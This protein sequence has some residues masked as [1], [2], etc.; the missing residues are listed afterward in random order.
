MTYFNF[1][2]CRV[3]KSGAAFAAATSE[4]QDSWFDFLSMVE[5]TGWTVFSRE[6]KKH[7]QS[8]CEFYE[9]SV[10]LG[11]LDLPSPREDRVLELTSCIFADNDGDDFTAS[12]TRVKIKTCVFSNPDSRYTQQQNENSQFATHATRLSLEVWAP[13]YCN[14]PT[15][16]RPTKLVLATPTASSAFAETQGLSASVMT[17]SKIVGDSLLPDSVEYKPT[18]IFVPTDEVS[19]SGACSASS[20]LAI[21]SEVDATIAIP[22]SDDLDDSVANL[23]S[24]GFVDSTVLV[25]TQNLPA[26]SPLTNSVPILESERLPD[27]NPPGLSSVA[28]G[29]DN[30]LVSAAV[31]ASASVDPSRLVASQNIPDSAVLIH[32][33]RFSGSGVLT[34]SSPLNDSALIGQSKALGGSRSILATDPSPTVVRTQTSSPDP[35]A[36]RSQ[37]SSDDD[38]ADKGDPA[39]A[40]TGNNLGLIIGIVV[41][42][43]VI[44]GL[45]VGVIVYRRSQGGNEVAVPAA[46]EGTAEDTWDPTAEFIRR[47]Q[48]EQEEE[49]TVDFNNPVFDEVPVNSDGEF[50]NISDEML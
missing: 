2:S 36:V 39:A 34:A 42:V 20:S 21:S 14:D 43:L 40:P 18:G 26:S 50:E 31:L 28:T 27:S 38:E 19:P 24:G 49:M 15:A 29:S 23:N 11:V 32:S 17:D 33:G 25:V 48:L 45:I 12:T 4:E 16:V 9:N 3:E 47:Q 46:A 5:C 6:N 8:N 30:F 41:G 10:S 1:T 44:V 13:E 22:P 7:I 37:T 35:S